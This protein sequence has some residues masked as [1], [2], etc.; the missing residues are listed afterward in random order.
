MKTDKQ[1]GFSHVVLV[2]MVVLLVGVIGFVAYRFGV[3]TS[4]R[5]QEIQTEQTPLASDL[6]IEEEK[7]ETVKVPSEKKK[8]EA[9]K[10]ETK[11]APAPAPEEKPVEDK[12]EKIY[13]DMTYVSA[14][15]DGDSFL[16]ESRLEKNAT[17]TCNFKLYKEGQE[18]VYATKKIS[19]SKTCKGS[20][21]ISDLATYSGW[22][23]YVWFDGSD[24]KTYAYQKEKSVSLSDPN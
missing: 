15:Q 18:K 7:S 4:T 14:S 3:I 2:A 1:Q 20:L 8:T 17:G 16:V 22:T 9:V 5:N 21:D 19:D 11:P 13:L 6:K 10:E 23:L 12:K 24:G